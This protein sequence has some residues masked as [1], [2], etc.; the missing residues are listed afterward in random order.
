MSGTKW[1]YSDKDWTYEVHFKNNGQLFTTHPND[2]TKGDDYWEQSNTTVDFSYNDK[3]SIYNGKLIGQDTI[4][5]IGRN[6][7]DTWEFRMTKK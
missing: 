7:N 6:Q 5:G 3:Y 2:K 1:L 4:V